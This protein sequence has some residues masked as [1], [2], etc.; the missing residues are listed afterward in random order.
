[1]SEPQGL[2][3]ISDTSGTPIRT[4]SDVSDNSDGHTSNL[5][6]P[7]VGVSHLFFW[8]HVIASERRLRSGTAR[9]RASCAALMLKVGAGNARSAARASCTFFPVVRGAPA[10]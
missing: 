8:S 4:L 2:S 5:S 7:G 10:G 6:P 9:R 1:M 3:E